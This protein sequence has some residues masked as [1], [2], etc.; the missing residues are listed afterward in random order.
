M[1][2]GT[3][4]GTFK[5]ETL[6]E[7]LDASLAQGIHHLQFNWG[8]AH[9]SGPLPEVIDEI[10]S[11]A[12]VE[13]KKR[14]MVVAAVAGNANMVDV[15]PEKRQKA[16]DK[17][18]MIIPVCSKIGTKVIATC[19][20]SRN[21]ESMWRNHP[22]NQSEST[23]KTL[24]DTL[25]KILPAAEAAGV[26]IAFEPEYN[27]V[28]PNA[29]LSRKLIDEMASP[30]LKVVMDAAN[31]FGKDDLPRMKE[32]LDEAFDLLGDYVAIAHGKDLDHGGDAGHLPAGSGK[33]DYA[34][35][36]KL[37]C[38]LSFDVPVILHGLTEKQLPESVAMLR[39][40]SAKYQ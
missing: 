35:Y 30:R 3:M 8:S 23:W 32:V 6:E 21:P 22:D 39:R 4:S 10:A 18:L 5:R 9:P 19:T 29:R 40:H 15:E 1:Q 17:L 7:T 36:V 31:I 37:L 34:H 12:G 38:S 26:D 28:C 13:F 2:V 25:E 16:I 27:N 11:Y 20:G 33:L 14:N 24:R